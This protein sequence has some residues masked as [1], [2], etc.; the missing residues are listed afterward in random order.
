MVKMRRIITYIIAIAF[1]INSAGQGYALRPM[2]LSRRADK[3]NRLHVPTASKNDEIR[4][5]FKVP[6]GQFLVMP[7]RKDG[8]IDPGFRPSRE[9]RSN[10]YEYLVDSDDS[11][12]EAVIVPLYERPVK[13]TTLKKTVDWDVLPDDLKEGLK[14]GAGT[15]LVTDNPETT[16]LKKSRYSVL[17]YEGKTEKYLGRVG[18][19]L[20]DGVPIIRELNGKEFMLEA[21]GIGVANQGFVS[22]HIRT[23][24]LHEITGGYAIRESE[25]EYDMLENDRHQNSL[26]KEGELPRAAAE[27]HFVCPEVENLVRQAPE[28][29]MGREEKEAFLEEFQNQVAIVLRW[30]P[31]TRRASFDLKRENIHMLGRAAAQELPQLHEYPHPENLLLWGKNNALFSFHDRGHIF[32]PFPPDYT[33]DLHILTYLS[34]R[35]GSIKELLGLF[36]IR[37]NAELYL[38]LGVIQEEKEFFDEFKRGFIDEIRKLDFSE[39]FAS[40]LAQTS[41]P[42]AF[43]NYLWDNYFT[44][45][46]YSWY[47][48]RGYFKSTLPR[49]HSN[50]PCMSLYELD[51][52]Y[53]ARTRAQKD[54][55]ASLVE[56]IDLD[57]ED[58]QKKERELLHS[59]E[60]LTADGLIGG[61]RREIYIIADSLTP[62]ERQLYEEFV[63][64]RVSRWTD[65]LDG[66]L[67]VRVCE[68]SEVKGMPAEDNVERLF[69]ISDDDLEKNFNDSVEQINGRTLLLLTK[70]SKKPMLLYD[71][72]GEGMIRLI[73][74]DLFFA[75][76]GIACLENRDLPNSQESPEGSNLFKL[77]FRSCS[78]AGLRIEEN[79]FIDLVTQKER[80][81]FNDPE[82][83]EKIIAQF[84]VVNGS[85]EYGAALL[86]YAWDKTLAVNDSTEETA[87]TGR[88]LIRDIDA[89]A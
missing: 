30:T 1:V 24:S 85:L 80:G 38:K 21:K 4:R 16:R 64:T 18:I 62:Q 3:T 25:E 20:L 36:L 7:Q 56:S 46:G 61:K 82:N 58:V 37:T 5:R 32:M 39:N 63:R 73:S 44:V 40:E 6:D 53:K 71:K 51:L 72:P 65:K 74:P 42:R 89:G 45:I 86:E 2:A 52:L 48:Q 81:K 76:I 14:I 69:L 17:M 66:A 13:I 55:K 8:I 47:K 57:A 79:D 34:M 11:L 23:R 68:A 67:S 49:A 78:K 9:F 75:L 84:F 15:V 88:K 26:F 33:D 54:N 60:A 83:R 28:E 27:I 43:V 77:T 22:A 19:L 50:S 70:N 87:M 35:G 29:E 59:V 12:K 31:S 10:L 41:T